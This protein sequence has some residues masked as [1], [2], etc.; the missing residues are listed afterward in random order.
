MRK[1]TN[2]K[3]VL[4][5]SL[6]FCLS[7]AYIAYVSYIPQER[8]AV[9]CSHTVDLSASMPENK[10]KQLGGWRGWTKNTS[11]IET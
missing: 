7:F 1:V 6:F 3:G 11:S 10:E 2:E 5:F 4:I 8:F 9:L